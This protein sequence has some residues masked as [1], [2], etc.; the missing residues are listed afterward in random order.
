MI[1]VLLRCT[2]G[3]T[4]IRRHCTLT[5]TWRRHCIGAS[6]W[7]YV[8]IMCY[9]LGR[10]GLTAE[11]SST[12]SINVVLIRDSFIECAMCICFIFL[13]GKSTATLQYCC[14]DFLQVAIKVN[15]NGI[16]WRMTIVLD[17]VNSQYI[18]ANKYDC[19]KVSCRWWLY[20]FVDSPWCFWGERH[21]RRRS[22]HDRNHHWYMI[23][24]LHYW[25]TKRRLWARRTSEWLAIT[26][27]ST[28]AFVTLLAAAR[29][30]ERRVFVLIVPL[31][32][33]KQW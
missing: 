23:R 15:M 13:D 3:V 12:K 4:T 25:S 16:V 18:Q 10:R 7:C 19:Y 9:F 2:I 17:R 31:S 32:M 11:H 30:D 5:L 26:L 8:D 29:R 33:A 21:T 27:S 20:T 6:R 14:A 24:R 28:D 22:K 1:V